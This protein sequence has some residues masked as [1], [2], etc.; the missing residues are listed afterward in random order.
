VQAILKANLGATRRTKTRIGLHGKDGFTVKKQKVIE[1]WG[2]EW[3]L[4]EAPSGWLGW[5]PCAE[6]TVEPVTSGKD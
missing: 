4:V 6:I 1:S 2:G 5:L 3:I